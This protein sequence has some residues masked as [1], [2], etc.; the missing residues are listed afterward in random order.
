MKACRAYLFCLLLLNTVVLCSCGDGNNSLYEA[1]R[2]LEVNP[3][4]A[5]SILESMTFPT[6]QRDRAWY[7]V[8]KTQ[9]DLRQNFPWTSDSLILTATNYY[10]S[11]RRSYRSAMAW[12]SQGCVYSKMN[13]DMAAIYAYLKAKDLFPDTLVRYY[14]L[15]EL[16]LGKHYHNKKMQDE[17]IY[18]LNCC[19]ANADRLNDRTLSYRATI[20]LWSCEFESG[21]V[22][23]SDSLFSRL[24]SEELYSG[25]GFNDTEVRIPMYIKGPTG[26]ENSD[27]TIFQ[28]LILRNFPLD[29]YRR[30][31]DLLQLPRGYSL[32]ANLFYHYEDYDSAYFYYKKAM[33]CAEIL[34]SKC[35]FADKLAE[36]S[37]RTER[38]DEAI[39]WYKIYRE[40]RDSINSAEK[41][42]SREITDMQY[43]HREELNE[44]K[45]QNRYKRFLILGTS[46]LLLFTLVVLLVFSIFKNREKKRI[47]NKQEELLSL[48]KEIRTGSITILES[49][50]REESQTNPEARTA[51]LNLYSHRLKLNKEYF[52]KTAEYKKLLSTSSGMVLTSQEKEK[53]MKVMNQSFSDSLV[54]IQIEYPGID[55]E[56][57][58]TLI[59]SSLHFRNEFISCLFGNV[60]AEAIRKRKYRLSKANP[61]F[62]QQFID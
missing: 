43:F 56:E 19:I 53:L 55:T 57:S 51:L 26:Y 42:D 10:G 49:Q 32:K 21:L 8:L 61:D 47:I 25:Y 6:S 33:E 44:E 16:N 39:Y 50:V 28:P 30:I 29:E 36:L 62:Y 41:S 13:N 38:Y 23:T 37:I 4:A 46:S 11:H 52:Q 7:A 45:M 35:L 18:Q 12:Y 9:A 20:I 5:D 31:D 27:D 58:F 54:D 15:T 48:E 14:A 22:N 2:L 3:E 59:L 60:T 17:A 40:L 24:Q 34:S 1:E